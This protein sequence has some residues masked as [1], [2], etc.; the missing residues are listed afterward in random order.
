MSFLLCFI[1][2]S[3]VY[4][5][6]STLIQISINSCLL[7]CLLSQNYFTFTNVHFHVVKTINDRLFPKILYDR[8]FPKFLFCSI[9][10]MQYLSFYSLWNRI[11]NLFDQLVL[12]KC[13][14]IFTS[15]AVIVSWYILDNI[16]LFLK[17]D[18]IS[19]HGH[20]DL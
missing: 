3:N 20:F 18:V 9:G 10:W 7:F 5:S 19:Y 13:H 6:K 1:L 17:I 15:Q 11:P 4:H 8:L 2:I 12:Q 14:Q 16:Y